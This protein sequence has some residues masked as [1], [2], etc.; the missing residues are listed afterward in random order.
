MVLFQAKVRPILRLFLS[1]PFFLT[2]SIFVLMH[3][4]IYERKHKNI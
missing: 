2:S 4:S 1:N 3:G